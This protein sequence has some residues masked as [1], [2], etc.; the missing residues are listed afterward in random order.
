MADQ[1]LFDWDLVKRMVGKHLLVGVDIED[2]GGKVVERR[3]FHGEVVRVSAE[4]GIVVQVDG[5]SQVRT[6]PLSVKVFAAK[7][8][9][10]LLFSSGEVVED[11]DYV[12]RW[13]IRR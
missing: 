1:K 6:L 13:P 11:P 12:A 7:P 2:G 3:Q 10:Y 5:S 4:E 9:H 8:G